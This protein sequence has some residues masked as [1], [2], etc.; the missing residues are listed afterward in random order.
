MQARTQHIPRMPEPA[1]DSMPTEPEESGS[2]DNTNP[3]DR[4]INGRYRLLAHRGSGRLGAIYEARDE[5]TSMTGAERHV[6]IQLLDGNLIASRRFTGEFERGVISLQGLAHPNLVGLLDA[7][8]DDGRFFIVME[9]QDSA[10]LRFVLND[11]GKLPLEETTAVVRAVGDALRYLHAKSFVHGNVKPENVLVTFDYEVRLLDVVPPEWPAALNGE[12]DQRDDVYGLA[13]LTY[14]M[15]TGRHPYNANTPV[16]ALRAGLKPA[17]VALLAASQWQALAAALEL[18]PER[19]TPTI[20]RF[21]EELGVTGDEKLRAIVAGVAGTAEP[22]SAGTA[23]VAEVPSAATDPWP[24]IEPA[25]F[26]PQAPAM[27]PA[28]AAQP[29]LARRPAPPAETAW[30]AGD[31][32]LPQRV[33]R[34]ERARPGMTGKLLALLL[35]VIL[36]AIGYLFQ[37]QLMEEGSALLASFNASR[38]QETPETPAV[39]TDTA[40]P[41]SAPGDAP[42][43]AGAPVEA[44][45]IAAAPTDVPAAPVDSAT[46]PTDLPAA[47]I[48]NAAE[49][50]DAP[51]AP[52]QTPAPA[53]A[54]TDAPVVASDEP[55]REAAPVVADAPAV[56]P[57]RFA[58]SEPVLTVSERDVAARIVIRRAGNT[59]ERASIAWWTAD[60][61]ARADQDFANLGRRVERFAPGETMRAVFV[62]LTNDTVAEPVKSFNVYL[63]RADSRGT[64]EPLSGMR[65]DIIDDD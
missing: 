20:V 24:T 49:P 6:A 59:A 44:P 31:I 38:T 39:P 30:S 56:G 33:V 7:G 28:P 25:P 63:G 40:R 46:V 45:V 2:R 3:L 64:A 23:A 32:P 19:R 50:V 61:S 9:L 1:H 26:A 13:C 4:L 5:Q 14:E 15:L 22:V 8:R 21:L 58:F 29:A 60:G 37:D 54:R 34:V 17:P 27:D 18:Q 47:P 10:S 16:E 52:V 35:L 57:P 51:A 62:P 48:D 36:G 11:A 41:V 42:M 55:A 53:T 65:V 12:P 43:I